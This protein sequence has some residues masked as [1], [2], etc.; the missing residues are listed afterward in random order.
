MMMN[1]KKSVVV[2][3]LSWAGLAIAAA[4]DGMTDKGIWFKNESAYHS[5]EIWIG[6]PIADNYLKKVTKKVPAA[7]AEPL[8]LGRVANLGAVRYMMNGTFKT[9]EGM[10]SWSQ[11]NRI[12][13]TVLVTFKSGL[14]DRRLYAELSSFD[15]YEPSI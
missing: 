7:M 2:L 5:G 14:L 13:G 1:S 6:S 11:I 15:E 9:Y 12:S 10:L 4:S 8:F 3:L